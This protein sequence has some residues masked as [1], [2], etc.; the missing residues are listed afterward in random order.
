MSYNAY[1]L[2]DSTGTVTGTVP[3][4][5]NVTSVRSLNIFRSGAGPCEAFLLDIYGII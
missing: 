5:N 4:R 2:K 3:G 1:Y